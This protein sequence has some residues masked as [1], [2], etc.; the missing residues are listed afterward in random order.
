MS[1]VRRFRIRIRERDLSDLKRRLAQVRWPER[2]T[3]DGWSQGIPLAYTRELCEY[4]RTGY[5]WRRCEAELNALPQYLTEL[6]GLDIHF[7]H[8]RSP[9]A[10]ALPQCSPMAGRA[11]SLSSPRSSAR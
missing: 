1:K 3:V 10:D 7:L 2:E 9:H 6:D 8:I 4:W 5:D 11:R